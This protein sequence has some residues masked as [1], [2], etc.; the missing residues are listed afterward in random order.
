MN[1]GTSLKNSIQ[2]CSTGSCEIFKDIP[3]WEGKYQVSN[4]GRIKSLPRMVVACTGKVYNRKERILKQTTNE[5]GYKVVYLSKEGKDYTLGVHRAI[6]LAFIANPEN[7]PMVNHINANRA[8]NWVDNLEWCT[9]AENI[10]HSFN[11]G[12]SDN[13]GDK[14]PRRVLTMEMVRAIREEL[15]NG[16]TPQQVAD[17]VG[18]KRRNVYAVRD[19]QNW[20]YD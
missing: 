1:T 16:K 9:N 2:K 6:A 7:K 19:R 4:I 11:L 14:H 3:G 13:K 5:D 20:N 8:D 15:A 10:Q 18:T 12:I 17:I